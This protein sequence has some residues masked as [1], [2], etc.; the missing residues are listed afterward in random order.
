M[1]TPKK[2]KKTQPEKLVSL[3]AKHLARRRKFTK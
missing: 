1:A 3:R 2:T